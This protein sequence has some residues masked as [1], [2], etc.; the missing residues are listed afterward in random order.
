M[1]KHIVGHGWHVV[2]TNILN[3]HLIVKTRIKIEL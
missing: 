1:V 3:N 2:V